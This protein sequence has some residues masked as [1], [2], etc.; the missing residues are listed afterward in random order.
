MYGKRGAASLSRILSLCPPTFSFAGFPSLGLPCLVDGRVNR[1][2]ARNCNS[3]QQQ[4]SATSP[5]APRHPDDQ[6]QLAKRLHCP[7]A[8]FQTE[9]FYYTK[10]YNK[11]PRRALRRDGREVHR[12]RHPQAMTRVHPYCASP[13]PERAELFSPLLV[14][15]RSI[16]ELLAAGHEQQRCCHVAPTDRFR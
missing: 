7:F 13:H 6:A 8:F 1:A 14:L 12:T 4:P 15:P 10:I 16:A 3:W 5:S 11:S 2:L 9:H